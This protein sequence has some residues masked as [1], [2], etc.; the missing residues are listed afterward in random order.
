VALEPC[1]QQHDVLSCCHAFAK[2]VEGKRPVVR[3]QG[4]LQVV[5]V[6]QV[7]VYAIFKPAGFRVQE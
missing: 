4:F 6:L 1:R 3:F 5:Q 7:G 2:E